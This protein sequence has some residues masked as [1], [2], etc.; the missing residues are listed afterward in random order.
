[1]YR[2]LAILSVVFFH[3]I[4]TVRPGDVS[5]VGWEM[6]QDPPVGLLIGFLM[7]VMTG[8]C[9]GKQTPFKR[10]LCLLGVW[11][12]QFVCFLIIMESALPGPPF[13]TSVPFWACSIALMAKRLRQDSER[14]DADRK[15]RLRAEKERMEQIRSSLA[16]K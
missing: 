13:W 15:A 10:R 7:L 4:V 5:I 16:K 1:M 2:L 11:C 3:F 8:P 9:F 6:F 14:E 12:V